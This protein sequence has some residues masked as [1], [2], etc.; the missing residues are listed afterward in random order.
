MDRKA[1][2]GGL[3]VGSGLGAGL[4][5]LLDPAMGRGRRTLREMGDRPRGAV[6]ETRGA[7]QVEEPLAGDWVS[8]ELRR[9]DTSGLG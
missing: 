1:L 4:M 9:D 5:F 6:G 7:L 2:L 3:A 8:E